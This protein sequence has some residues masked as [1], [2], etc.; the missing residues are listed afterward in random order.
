MIKLVDRES[1][2]EMEQKHA[3]IPS[4]KEVPLIP[5]VTYSYP[6]LTKGTDDH[7]FPPTLL[8]PDFSYVN[9]STPT[10]P[11]VEDYTIVLTSEKGVRTYAYCSRYTKRS[12]GEYIYP[13]VF[14]I[15]S[16]FPA[17]SFYYNLSR[18]LVEVAFK[19]VDNNKLFSSVHIL[20]YPFKEQLTTNNHNH[21]MGIRLDDKYK[22]SLTIMSPFLQKIGVNASLFLF[23][24]VLAER[25]IIVTG[26]SVADISQAVQVIIKMIQPLQWPHSL[27][28]IIPDSQVELCHNPTPFIYGLLRHNLNQIKDALINNDLHSIDQVD[29]VLFDVDQGVILPAPL[30]SR[31][32]VLTVSTSMGYPDALA[33]NLYEKFQ[34]LLS[35]KGN[36]QEIDSKIGEKITKWFAK[37]FGHVCSFGRTALSSRTRRLMI[38]SHR[39]KTSRAFLEWFLESGIYQY[40]VQLKLDFDLDRTMI[41]DFERQCKKYAPKVSA[42]K[43]CYSTVA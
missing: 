43:E 42:L 15:V 33:K 40:F 31:A 24:A 22:P 7:L 29:P 34:K 12:R 28:P 4:G 17:P 39:K 25:R 16:A 13:E 20:K 21:L 11:L 30:W 18:S 23:L 26:S 41:E 32:S 2:S 6:P 1:A 14:V 38:S 19:G 27:V 8:Y 10:L 37:Q 36:A 3:K 9:S 5:S 35:K